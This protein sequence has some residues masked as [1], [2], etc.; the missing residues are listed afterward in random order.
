MTKVLDLFENTYFRIVFNIIK[1]V[2]IFILASYI[3]FIAIQKI[4]NNSSIFGYRVFSVASGSMIPVYNVNDV[5]L[6]KDCNVNTL[7]VGEDI[8]YVGKRGGV[9]GLVVS[10]RIIKIDKSNG[11]VERIFTQGLNAE[12]TDPSIGPEQVLGRVVEVIPII[13]PINHILKNIFGFF[14][15]IFLPLVLIICLEVIE[16]RLALKLDKEELIRIEKEIKEKEDKKEEKVE[17][18]EELIRSEEEEKQEFD[19]EVI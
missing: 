5:I 4:T 19:E 9:E 6:V 14:F 2:L 10:H 3:L 8:V 16:T 13:T 1:V 11:K 15:L 12:G 7:Q 17:E 18:I